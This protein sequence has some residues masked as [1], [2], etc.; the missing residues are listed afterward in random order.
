[1]RRDD[2]VRVRHMLD[3][4][5]EVLSFAKNKSREDLDS[6]RMLFLSIVKSIEIIGEAASKVTQLPRKREKHIRSCRG[7]ISLRCGTVLSMSTLISITTGSG[8]R[9]QMTSHR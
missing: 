2:L 1:M 6:D 5:K 4:A 7:R 3:A 9:L 8:I